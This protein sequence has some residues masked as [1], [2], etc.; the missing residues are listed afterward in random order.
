MCP[1]V[2]HTQTVP[3]YPSCEHS[4]WHLAV[5]Q[6]VAAI[7]TF[8]SVIPVLPP[9]MGLPLYLSS[10]WIQELRLREVKRLAHC[11]TAMT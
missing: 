8:G 5:I 6:G 7:F 4:A 3:D 1:S 2:K 9:R 10:L 11:L